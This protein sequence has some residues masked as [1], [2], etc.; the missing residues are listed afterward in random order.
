[1]P[2]SEKRKSE[3]KN[4]EEITNEA[5]NLKNKM[6]SSLESDHASNKE[7]KPA[8]LR[9]QSIDETV[10]SLK[11]KKLGDALL[12]KGILDV[13]KQWLEPLPDNTLP[14][15]K[16]KK[17]MLDVLDYLPVKRKHLINSNGI[18]KIVNFYSKNSRE[19]DDVRK[20]ANKLVK[21]WTF[22]FAKEDEDDGMC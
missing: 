12:E 9:L 7:S 21:K 17:G 4:E 13:I 1:M 8:I 14:N 19:L 15:V 10:N 22:L 6:L 3:Q 5:L 2:K 11:T 18:G 20:M 16:I